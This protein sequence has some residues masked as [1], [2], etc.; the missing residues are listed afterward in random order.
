MI[1]NKVIGIENKNNN[2]QQK[3]NNFLIKMEEFVYFLDYS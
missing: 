2:W 1:Y 3:L